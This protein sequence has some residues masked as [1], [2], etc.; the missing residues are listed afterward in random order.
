MREYIAEIDALNDLTGVLEFTRAVCR[1][2]GVKRQSYHFSPI[3]SE[4]TSI[5]TVVHAE[6]FSEDWLELYRKSDFR[7]ADPIP[8]R[9]YE[10]GGLLTWR[11]ARVMWPNSELHETYFKAMDQY[12]L[13]HGF[14]L[15]LYGPRGR[16]AYAS[17]D[18]GEPLTEVDPSLVSL[19]RIIAMG[20]HQRLCN[21]IDD[22]RKRAELSERE[23]EVLTWMARGKTTREIGSILDVSPD[24]VKTYKDRIFQKLGVN[25]RIGAII[26]G[27][28]LG[29]IYA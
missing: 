11:D 1:D 14:G 29:L 24:T 17:F 16:T 2:H 3:F 15:P 27:L 10:H 22:P 5:K 25:D 23:S 26:R 9:T 28:R 8:A 21:I 12:D 18:F 20:G 19:V 6:G 13:I 7:K 4:P